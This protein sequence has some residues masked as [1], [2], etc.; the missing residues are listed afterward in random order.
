MNL[1]ITAEQ[2]SWLENSLKY[3]KFGRISKQEKLRIESSQRSFFRITSQDHNSLILMVVPHGIDESVISFV[4]KAAIFKKYSVNVPNV[5]SYDLELGL[6][7]VEDFG[8]KIY[9][10]NLQEDPDYF[11]EKAINE[12][13]NIQSIEKDINSCLLYTSPSPRD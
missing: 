5:Y 9:Q 10:Y 6:I 4:D 13:V 12:L 1:E 8:D 7:L 3:L 2:E 11:Y